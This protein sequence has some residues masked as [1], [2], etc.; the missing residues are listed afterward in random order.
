MDL[1][2]HAGAQLALDEAVGEAQHGALHHVG[3]GALH[4]HVERH[5]L[6]AAARLE[7]GRINRGQVAPPPQQRFGVAAAAGG[8]L[9]LLA[10]LFDAGE[11]SEVGVDEGLG[12]APLHARALGESVRADA[13]DHAEV[14]HLGGVAHLRLDI[15][16]FDAVGAG[17]RGGVDVF[18]ALEGLDQAG[19]AG[20]VREHAQLDLR[21]VGADKADVVTAAEAVPGAGHEGGAHLRAELGAHGDV[22]QVG[23]LGREPPGGGDG[24]VVVGVDALGGPADQRRERFDVGR[25]QLGQFA[26]LEDVIDNRVALGEPL[27]LLRVGREALRGLARLG[28]SEFLEEHDA[29]LLGRGDAEFVPGVFVDLGGEALDFVIQAGV[30]LFELG[31]VERDA[32][33][34]HLDQHIDQRQFEV[35]VERGERFVLL[36][37]RNQ[38]CGQAQRHVG[39][40]GRVGPGFGGGHFEHRFLLAALADQRLDRSHFDAQPR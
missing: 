9:D 28:Q 38:D 30:Q 7:I 25:A 10:P 39:V 26:P 1:E 18:A 15:G 31:G 35:A 11:A 2:Q 16:D 23:A 22:L 6:R 29:E 24:L 32:G 40:G 19:V 20:E 27:E 14:H 34:L 33:E 5:P 12:V 4:G 21:V 17:C 37:L 3:G 36:E 8:F 13:V